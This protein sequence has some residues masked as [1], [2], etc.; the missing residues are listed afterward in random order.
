MKSN[1]RVSM[2]FNPLLINEGASMVDRA[3]LY[4]NGGYKLICYMGEYG[5]LSCNF[6]AAEFVFDCK[7]SRI[8]LIEYKKSCIPPLA[9][10]G[11]EGEVAK[12]WELRHKF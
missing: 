11:S 1:Y 7:N 2:Y 8:P 6:D 10:L 5:T 9:K 4:Y 3:P 12:R